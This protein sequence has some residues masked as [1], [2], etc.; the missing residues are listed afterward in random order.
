MPCSR[1]ARSPSVS[2][3][4]SSSPSRPLRSAYWSAR[5]ALES[6]RR[7]PMSVDL[8]SSTEPAVARRRRVAIEEVVEGLEV[9]GDLAVLH[10]RLRHAIVGA[11]LAALGHVGGGDL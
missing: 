8:P 11:G 4:R 1:S 7:R 2:R 10:R 5:I 3:D 6:C 9:P